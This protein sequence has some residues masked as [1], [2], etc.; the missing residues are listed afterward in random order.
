MMV[1]GSERM[2]KLSGKGVMFLHS[3]SNAIHVFKQIS[4]ILHPFSCIVLLH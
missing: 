3:I 1:S 4:P 2:D